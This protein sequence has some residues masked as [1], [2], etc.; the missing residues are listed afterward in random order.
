LSP[1]ASTNGLIATSINIYIFRDGLVSVTHRPLSDR[2]IYSWLPSRII[3]HPHIPTK[4]FY[5]HIDL[6]HAHPRRLPRSVTHPKITLGQ[7]HLMR[8]SFRIGFQKNKMQLISTSILSF[9]LSIG[10]D[11]HTIHP[12]RDITIHPLKRLTSLLV[13]PK[14]GT[15]PLGH[16]YV[17]SVIICHMSCGHSKPTCTTYS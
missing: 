3:D 17:S 7:A 15:S 16:V 10:L 2:C 14:S 6:T 12:G 8:D 1:D 11:N 9:L 13:N 4:V 5:V